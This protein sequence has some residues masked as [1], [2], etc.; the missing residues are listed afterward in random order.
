MPSSARHTDD[1][2]RGFHQHALFLLYHRFNLLSHSCDQEG[3]NGLNARH[4]T[5]ASYQ[6]LPPSHCLSCTTTSEGA[7]VSDWQIAIALTRQCML[8]FILC[9]QSMAQGWAIDEHLIR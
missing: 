8:C 4:I 2:Q 6:T 5:G 7:H 1:D 9:N 3:S